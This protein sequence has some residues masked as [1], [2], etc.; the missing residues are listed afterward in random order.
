MV[1]DRKIN[2]IPNAS[3]LQEYTFNKHFH[4]YIVKLDN[5]KDY[6]QNILTKEQMLKINKLVENALKKGTTLRT[7]CGYQEQ[8]GDDKKK[9][10]VYCYKHI[11]KNGY[12]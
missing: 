1:R 6:A 9:R 2:R 12:I 5:H 4:G 3:S 10:K 8:L 11:V 7:I